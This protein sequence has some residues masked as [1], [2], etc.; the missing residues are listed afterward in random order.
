MS[1]NQITLPPDLAAKVEERIASGAADDA[2]SIVREGLA[3]LEAEDARKF[4]ALREK[5]A[6]SLNDPRPSVPADEAFS[7]VMKALAEYKKA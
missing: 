3:A 7:R 6:R 1:S 4:E 2:V 5:I